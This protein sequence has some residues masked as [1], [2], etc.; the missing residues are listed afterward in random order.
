MIAQMRYP[1]LALLA[2]GVLLAG[3]AGTTTAAEPPGVG[4][5]APDFTLQTPD[6]RSLTLSRLQEKRGVLLVFFATWCPAC[7]AEVPE[8]KAFVDAAR[9]EPLLVY[10]VNF[11]QSA[12]VVKRFA[13]ENELNY[14]ILLD[15]E[16]EVARDYGV[17]GIPLLVGIDGE[18]VIRFRDHGLPEDREALVASL[19]KGLPEDDDADADDKPESTGTPP[20]SAGPAGE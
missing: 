12:A 1:V 9:K 6:G 20:A 15:K 10:G 8:L 18:G 17:H 14:R 5:E 13:E 2:A 11:R 16:G 3:R 4:D 19:V 7:R